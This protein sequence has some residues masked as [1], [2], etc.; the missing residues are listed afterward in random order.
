[1]TTLLESVPPADVR[2]RILTVDAEGGL[3]V[4]AKP[5]PRGACV[6]S[7]PDGQSVAVSGVHGHWVRLSFPLEGWAPAALLA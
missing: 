1:M 5:V 4:W 3:D 2:G 6:G 7:L